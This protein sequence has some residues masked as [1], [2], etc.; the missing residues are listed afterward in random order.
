MNPFCK[1]K[2]IFGE[3]NKGI[4][5]TRIFGVALWDVV[6]T[7]IMAFVISKLLKKKFN[8]M[9]LL[10]FILA[11]IIHYIFCVDTAVNKA[12]DTLLF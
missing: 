12:I 9:L 4:H 5:S 7:T 3:P 11:I 1:Y 6:F 2:N 8:D 10:L